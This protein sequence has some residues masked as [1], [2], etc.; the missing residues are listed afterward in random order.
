M[1]KQELMG[2]LDHMDAANA[3]IALEYGIHPNDMPGYRDTLKAKM[4]L[5]ELCDQEFIYGKQLVK[6]N[7]TKY[8][9]CHNKS[10]SVFDHVDEAYKF[11]RLVKPSIARL[12]GVAIIKAD[13]GNYTLV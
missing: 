10:M 13:Q 6:D 4:V 12:F 7:E 9:A 11:I 5:S 3:K 1:T 2:M 8:I